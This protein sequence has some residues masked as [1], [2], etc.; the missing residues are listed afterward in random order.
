MIESFNR[1]ETW[2]VENGIPANG[3]EYR[4]PANGDN[5]DA[6]V[7]MLLVGDD[8]DLVDDDDNKVVETATGEVNFIN[9][10]SKRQELIMKHLMV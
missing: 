4:I 1:A 8:H 5:D 10:H 3:E 6:T 9:S 2:L 7:C